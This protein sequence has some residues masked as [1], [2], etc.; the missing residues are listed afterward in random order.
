[1]RKLGIADR[2]DEMLF[3]GKNKLIIWKGPSIYTSQGVEN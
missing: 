3:E 1:M 2:E